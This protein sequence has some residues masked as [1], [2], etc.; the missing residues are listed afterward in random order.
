MVECNSKS[1]P[2]ILC[3]SHLCKG[4]AFNIA[5]RDMKFITNANSVACE[6]AWYFTI[7]CVG[8]LNNRSG[9]PL[10]SETE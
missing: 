5:M 1:C 6:F 2:E 3:L 7:I 10:S 4:V 8:V 9:L